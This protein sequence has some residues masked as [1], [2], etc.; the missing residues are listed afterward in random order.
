MM[1]LHVLSE[2]LL[3]LYNKIYRILMLEMDLFVLFFFEIVWPAPPPFYDWCM[4]VK[5]A[6]FAIVSHVG[7]CEISVILKLM[8]I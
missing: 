4:F 6:C 1:S 3:I 7:L 2:L 8:Q 5:P